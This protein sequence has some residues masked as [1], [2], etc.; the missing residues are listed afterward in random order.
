MKNIRTNFNKD[1]KMHLACSNG[2]FRLIMKNIYFK[3]GYAYATDSYIL[4]K[5]NLS[6]CSTL[7]KDQIELLNGKMLSA[8]NYANILKYDTITVSEDGIEATKGEDK[9]FFY[10]YQCDSKFPDAEK[11][12]QDLL[13]KQTVPLAEVGLNLGYLI[14][15]NSSL[16]GSLRCKLTFKGEC[17]AVVFYSMETSSVGIIMPVLINN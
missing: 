13:N 8:K 15:L 17:N 14:K 16:S 11:L 5:N 6:E 4:V 12:I 2:D 10:F 1:V 3:D 9:A 7:P